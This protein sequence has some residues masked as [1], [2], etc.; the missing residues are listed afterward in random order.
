MTSQALTVQ[1]IKTLCHALKPFITNAIVADCVA[2]NPNRFI[3]ILRKGS[4]KEKLFFCFQKPLVCLYL[5]RSSEGFTSSLLPHPLKAFLLNATLHSIEVLNE[6]RI[7]SFSFYSRD[8]LLQLVAEFFPK[9]PN[10]YLLDQNKQILISLYPSKDL[11]Y[12][13]PSPPTYSVVSNETIRSLREVEA[14]FL[15]SLFEKEKNDLSNRIRKKI[16]R[17]QKLIQKLQSALKQA[18]EWESI[19]HEGELLKGNFHLLKRGIKEIKVW[20]WLNE[21]EMSLH[22]DPRFSPQQI[23]SSRFKQSKKM[24]KSISHLEKQLIKAQQTVERA[25][26]ILSTLENILSFAELEQFKQKHFSVPS[27]EKQQKEFSSALPY[28]EYKSKAGMKI[29]VGK[30]AKN[31]DILTFRLANGLDWWLHVKDLPGSHVIIRTPKG[32]EPDQETIQDALQLALHYSRARSEGQAEIC[33]TQRKFVSRLGAHQPGRVQM[34]KHK[35]IFIRLDANRL[36]LL[37][38]RKNQN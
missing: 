28:Y 5:A 11:N 13:L 17:G 33:L 10:Y 31:N 25:E 2:L 30:N 38:E 18:Q 19:Q 37:Q 15:H 4:R 9:H 12:Q 1:E 6:D 27:L 35:T 8:R 36:K 7:L 24:F 29:W 26:K 23:V 14:Q 16:V 32:K 22:L 20:D 21:K 3:L 34:A